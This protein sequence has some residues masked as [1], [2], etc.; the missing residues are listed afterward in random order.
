MSR[1]NIQ[2]MFSFRPYIAEF[3]NRL[4]VRRIRH[5]QRAYST[6]SLRDFV[7]ALGFSEPNQ[8]SQE[9]LTQLQWNVGA[10]NFIEPRETDSFRQ[11]INRAC[12]IEEFGPEEDANK[13]SSDQGLSG[14]DLRRLIKYSDLLDH[15]HQTS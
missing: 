8:Q 5:I 12:R 2:D 9:I 15:H 14:E 11:A 10:D 3:K 1:K 7:S 4:L 13:R 6:I